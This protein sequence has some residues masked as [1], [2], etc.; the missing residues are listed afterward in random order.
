MEYPINNVIRGMMQG[1]AIGQ[2]LR[3]AAVEREALARQKM[4]DRQNQQVADAEM[5]I[6]LGQATRP[7]QNGMVE[8]EGPTFDAPKEVGGFLPGVRPA[9]GPADPARTIRYE[10]GD[11]RLLQGEVL[12]PAEQAGRGMQAR[13]QLERALEDMRIDEVKRKHGA[14]LDTYGVPITEQLAGHFGLPSGVR[15]LPQHL[16][17]LIRADAYG[18]AVDERKAARQAKPSVTLKS[19]HVSTDDSGSQNLVQE[20]SDGTVVEKPL[21]SRGRRT[22]EAAS[23][24]GGPKKPSPLTLIGIDRRKKDALHRVEQEFSKKR[25]HSDEER[26]RL[27]S[28]KQRIQD[29]YEDELAR[30]GVPVQH[31][32]YPQDK[33]AQGGGS[34]SGSLRVGA[35]VRLKDG[36]TVTIKKLNAD[37]TFEY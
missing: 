5:Q 14:E 3:R 26:A 12:T 28:E 4:L 21:K 27:R 11:G 18:A 24:E 31:F 9:K 13:L 7:I 37:G 8:G 30:L 33:P 25:V 15:V 35:S 1:A 20:Y 17:D 34:P 19:S 6:R 10:T 36:R 22:R 32:E 2:M 16:D 29:D 23:G